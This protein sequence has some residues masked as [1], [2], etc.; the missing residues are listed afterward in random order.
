M[1]RYPEDPYDRIWEPFC[2][3]PYWASI[4]TTIKVSNLPKDAFEVPS[5][6]LQ[7][8]VIPNNATSLKFFWDAMEETDDTLSQYHL[9]MHF[10]EVQPT[11]AN[12]SRTFNV[13]LNGELWEGAFKPNYLYGDHIYTTSPGALYQY[14]VSLNQLNTAVL[15]PILNAV[16]IYSLLH[17]KEVATDARDGKLLILMPS[18]ACRKAFPMCKQFLYIYLLCCLFCNYE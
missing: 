3:S 5:V 6:V 2:H 13:C 10:A 18:V 9:F 11:A 12:R 8:A 7:T 4:S 14:N 15:P 1:H 16:E 17:V